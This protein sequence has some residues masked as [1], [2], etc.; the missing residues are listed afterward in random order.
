M[1]HAQTPDSQLRVV[2][3]TLFVHD[4]LHVADT[5]DIG[6]YIRSQ[7]FEQ[8]FGGSEYTDIQSL[9]DSLRTKYEEAV[10]FSENLVLNNRD[11]N[12][13]SMDSIKRIISAGL[14]VLAMNGVAPAQRQAQTNM[15]V[16]SS[17]KNGEYPKHEIEIS[18][19]IAPFVSPFY[20]GPFEDVVR[21]YHSIPE[22]FLGSINLYYHLYFSKLHSLDVNLSWSAMKH[23]APDIYVRHYAYRNDY[24]HYLGLQAGYCIHFFNTEKIS[25]YSSIYLGATLFLIGDGAY[26]EDG[27][28]HFTEIPNHYPLKNLRDLCFDFQ[29]NYLGIR[30]GKHNAANIELGFGSQGMLKIGYSY[31]F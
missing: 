31:K 19:G 3:D 1:L 23:T 11:Q 10:T 5:L 16:T 4:T 20:S 21:D 24:V 6:E 17:T 25:L 27:I 14:I 13:L 26:Y 9:P 7:T 29:I 30:I 8:L 18:Y 22:I 2:Y 15:A 12:D 28:N